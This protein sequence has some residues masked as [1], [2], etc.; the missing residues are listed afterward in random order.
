LISSDNLHA[1]S[2]SDHHYGYK[3]SLQATNT[4]VAIVTGLRHELVL[5]KDLSARASY[6]RLSE[7]SSALQTQV[8]LKLNRLA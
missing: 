4:V 1:R 7:I 8:I 3:V 2:V 5:A 6:A